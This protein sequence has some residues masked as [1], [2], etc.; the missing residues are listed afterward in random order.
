MILWTSDDAK[1]YADMTAI[2][3]LPTAVR[4]CDLD[5]KL[6]KLTERGWMNV[7]T[8]AEAQGLMFLCPTCFV[9]NRGRAGTHS[10]LCWFKDRGVPDEQVPLPGRWIPSGTSIDDITF[11]GP[12]AASVLFQTCPTRYHG[13]IRNGV[14]TL[15]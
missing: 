1:P 15:S 6:V 2:R 8:L 10:G 5:A 13:F 3:P 4:L 7:D 11:V 12:A 14:A 9:L